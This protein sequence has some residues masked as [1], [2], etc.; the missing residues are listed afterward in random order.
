M[1][2]AKSL[3]VPIG[4]IIRAE[5]DNTWSDY[6]WFKMT[7]SIVSLADGKVRNPSSSYERLNG[8]GSLDG[9]RVTAQGDNKGERRLYGFNI[10][11]HDQTFVELRDAENMA[12]TLGLLWKRMEKLRETRGEC[13]TFA[14]FVGRVAESLGKDTQIMEVISGGSWHHET[15]YKYRDIGEG[16][17]WIDWLERQWQTKAEKAAV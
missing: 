10:R 12:Q 8:F 5:N 16:I 14:Q 11:F 15:E 2:K 9:L 4:I 7:G 17:S 13:K 6:S 1:S 3:T